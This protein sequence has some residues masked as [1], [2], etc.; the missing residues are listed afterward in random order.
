MKKVIF[1]TMILGVGLF[2]GV[3]AFAEDQ[4]MLQQREGR[5]SQDQGMMAGKMGMKGEMM[6]KGMH[7][8]PTLIATTDGGVVMFFGGKL[9]KY[10]AQLNL[11][12]EVEIKGGPMPKKPLMEDES[13][14]PLPTT[15]TINAAS[16]TPAVSDTGGEPVLQP[17]S[18]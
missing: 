12:K 14:M 9:A 16:Q 17:I 5:E 8:Q 13:Q 6:K 1:F 3:S 15:E 18:S 7:Q 11:V 4:D 10:D 2:A